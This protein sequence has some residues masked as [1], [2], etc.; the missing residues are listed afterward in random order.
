MAISTPTAATK[1]HL[2][3]SADDPKQARA[4]LAALVDKFNTLLTELEAPAVSTTGNGIKVG[5][6][7][8]Y[9][10]VTASESVTIDLG[11]L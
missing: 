6:G 8:L 10:D 9:L 5:S 1:A 3:S 7:L 2:D 11:T 4:E